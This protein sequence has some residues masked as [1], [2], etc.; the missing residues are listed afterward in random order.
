MEEEIHQAPD[1]IIATKDSRCRSYC[2][3]LNNYTERDLEEIDVLV[4][5]GFC[6]FLI[7]GKEV[8]AQGTPHL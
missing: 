3:T 7:Y 2:W 6:D 5:S 4:E 8:G 1:T